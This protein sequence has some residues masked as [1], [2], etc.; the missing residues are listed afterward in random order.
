[1]TYAKIAAAARARQLD[2]FAALHTQGDPHL[3]PGTRT[4]LLL[5]P[6]E[7]GYWDSLTASPEWRDG[8]ANPVDR[9]SQRVVGG[10][11]ASFGA[12]PLYPFGGPPFLP[13]IRWALESG[14]VHKSPVTLLVHRDAGL[15]VSFRGA[16]ALP[17]TLDLP[18]SP[19]S[20]CDTCATKPC[21]TACTVDALTATGYDTAACKNFLARPDGAGCMTGGCGVRT[22][23][24]AGRTH[25]R[26]AA[27]SAYH[28]A[29]FI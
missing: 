24:P 27:H 8:A 20:P 22:A 5:G 1:M 25:G 6:G 26:V 19:P 21:R 2:I 12:T 23:C 9:W 4:L 3:P 14:W 10:L 29:Q 17:R 11:A 15:W 28:M 16:L 18:P 13:F 7:P